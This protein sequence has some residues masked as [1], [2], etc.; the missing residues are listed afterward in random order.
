[1]K[2]KRIVNT[3]ISEDIINANE[4]KVLILFDDEMYTLEDI[5][6]EVDKCY[7]WYAKHSKECAGIGLER[8]FIPCKNEWNY[9]ATATA[10]L[11]EQEELSLGRD[12]NYCLLKADG[13]VAFAGYSRGGFVDVVLK[14]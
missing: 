4:G 10:V 11:N 13:I 7:S 6:K 14:K 3:L 2:Q 5:E 9:T 8:V 1:M 12:C